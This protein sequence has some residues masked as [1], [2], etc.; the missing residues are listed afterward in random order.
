MRFSLPVFF[1]AWCALFSAQAQVSVEVVLEQQ[2]FLPGESLPVAVKITNRSGQPLHLGGDANWL[3]FG[4]ES[5]DGFIVM[6]RADVPVAGEFDLGSSE[7]ATRRVDLAPY[8]ALSRQGRYRVVATVRIR[9][10]N[11][12]M[13][14]PKQNFDVVNGA[15][16]WSQDFG[17]PAPADGTNRPPEVRKYTLEEAN[18][19]HSQLRMYVRVSDQPGLQVFKVSAIGPMVS[20]SQPEAQLDRFSNLHVLYQSG[21]SSFL[22]SVV[23]PD[24]EIVQREIY[25]Y[26]DSRPRLGANDD[27]DILVIGG[28]R[29]VRPAERPPPAKP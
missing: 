26:R 2:Q 29:R 21:A 12:E 10:W 4:V 14:S 9:D 15:T 3:T 16:L 13:S 27:G 18:Y 17:V 23:T 1:L 6:K 7:V 20:F 25:D 11:A 22:Y 8:F 19:L 5:E 24:G 28:V